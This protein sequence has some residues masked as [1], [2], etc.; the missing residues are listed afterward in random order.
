VFITL[1]SIR[2]GVALFVKKP[3]EFIR[4]YANRLTRSDASVFPLEWIDA[5][6]G[7]VS[8]PESG[9]VVMNR[10]MS[11]VAVGVAWMDDGKAVADLAEFRMGGAT[12]WV[13]K[14]VGEIAGKHKA[15]AVVISYGPAV[16]VKAELEAV[17]GELGVELWDLNTVQSA[18]AAMRMFDLLKEESITLGKSDPLRD[19]FLAARGKAVGDR[20][21]FDRDVL[22]DQAP[23][24]AVSV[25]VD[26]AVQLSLSGDWWGIY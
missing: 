1:R 10:G 24:I 8:A 7:A 26:V 12:G 15:S 19:A 5:A 20:W 13:G 3:A 22:V 4:A 16:V 6:F 21:R 17:C 23:L 11:S 25:A 2:S 14:R 18:S 9:L